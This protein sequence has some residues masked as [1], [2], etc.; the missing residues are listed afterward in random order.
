MSLRPFGYRLHVDGS[1]LI[2]TSSQIGHKVAADETAGTA[3]DYSIHGNIP[4]NQDELKELG[5]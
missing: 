5:V 2:A 1:D 3:N 4:R